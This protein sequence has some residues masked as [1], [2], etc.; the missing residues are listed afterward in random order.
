MIKETEYAGGAPS[1]PSMEDEGLNAYDPMAGADDLLAP[2][3][4]EEGL[5]APLPDEN[6]AQEASPAPRNRMLPILVG[7]GFL[8]FAMAMAYF[9]FR[10]EQDA[11]PESFA[12]IGG[13]E[14]SLPPVMGDMPAP[15]AEA[16]P[17][18][19]VL[20]EV[21]AGAPDVPGILASGT[22]VVADALP[23]VSGGPLSGFP[24]P[25]ADPVAAQPL[26]V[27]VVAV[28][29]ALAPAQ[30]AGTVE[31]KV[32]QLE[33]QVRTLETRLADMQA[34][35]VRLQELEARL[36]SLSAAPAPQ[37]AA[38]PVARVENP[39]EPVAKADPA[40]AKP[41]VKK[42]VSAKAPKWELRSVASDAAWV[43]EA[44]KPDVRRVIV[45]D[46]LDGIGRVTAIRKVEGVWTVEGTKGKL[47]P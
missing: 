7:G 33:E 9:Q 31:G 1:A 37:K 14:A 6:V 19:F 25:V 34:V 22:P 42:K 23:P 39:V 44:G 20:P 45:G 10:P 38:A 36:A 21:D 47:K 28:A 11:A 40:P 32:A 13:M 8:V 35:Q 30:A 43:G 17:Q 24:V 3:L 5:Q 16:F 26:P 41:A 27:P 46:T 2:S 29:P 15:Q 12:P 18:P 4:E